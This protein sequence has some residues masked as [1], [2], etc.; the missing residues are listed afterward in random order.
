MGEIH[1]FQ[2]AAE[3]VCKHT[4]PCLVDLTEEQFSLTKD[5]MKEQDMFKSKID[6]LKLQ[7][8][9]LKNENN[10]IKNIL[11]AD[12]VLPEKSNQSCTSV[13]QGFFNIQAVGA[14]SNVRLIYFFNFCAFFPSFISNTT[15]VSINFRANLGAQ[16]A[17]NGISVLQISIIIWGSTPPDT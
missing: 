11:H 5:S 7:I 16:N 9:D 2:E 12:E 8:K 10:S 3:K 17:G 4:S 1:R 13:N 15:I 6:S 14:I